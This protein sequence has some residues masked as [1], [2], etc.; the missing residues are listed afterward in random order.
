MYREV[1]FL[2]PTFF[3][4]PETKRSTPALC[5]GK[6]FDVRSAQK[7]DVYRAPD[8][9]VF[10][11]GVQAKGLCKK[12]RGRKKNITFPLAGIGRGFFAHKSSVR[13]RRGWAIK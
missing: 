8:T 4:K 13:F 11:V 3:A 2:G 9:G 6:M 5:G 10:G 7:A 12:K 1:I